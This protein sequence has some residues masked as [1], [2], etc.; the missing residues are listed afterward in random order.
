MLSLVILT[1][2]S[3]LFLKFPFSFL[4]VGAAGVAVGFFFGGLFSLLNVL[5][6]AVLTFVTPL[7]Y[8]RSELAL[9]LIMTVAVNSAALTAGYIIGILLSMVFLPF[10]LAGKLLSIVVGIFK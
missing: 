2:L 5:P 4:V 6:V 1:A 7:V 9:P 3:L 8:A 10:R